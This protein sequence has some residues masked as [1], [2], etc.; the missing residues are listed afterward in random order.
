MATVTLTSAD[1]SS[2][3]IDFT[4]LATKHDLNALNQQLGATMSSVSDAIAAASAKAEANFATIKAGIL[5]LDAQIQAF[6]NSPGTISPA[7][8]ATLDKIVADSAT[9]AAAA[10]VVVT[11]GGGGGPVTAPIT[12]TPTTA[13]LQ[14]GK[15]IQLTT[16]K[17]PTT[18]SVDVG[19]VKFAGTDVSY[20]APG[21]MPPGNAPVLAT[22]TVIGASP[23]E[24]ATTVVTL[25]L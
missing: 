18:A 16:N 23:F 24:S 20:T 7:D 13:T 12:I 22:I 17:T 9:L 5:A 4:D 21:T 19:V 3:T 25:T 10:Q 15:T 8:Q 1:G 2:I 11:P 14:L 6:N